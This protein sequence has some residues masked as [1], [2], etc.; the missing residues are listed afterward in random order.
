M[1]ILENNRKNH[2]KCKFSYHKMTILSNVH[3]INM[4]Q[5]SD[6]NRNAC[7]PNEGQSQPVMRVVLIFA[8]IFSQSPSPT[9]LLGLGALGD[10][11]RSLPDLRF[12]GIFG[13]M[14]PKPQNESVIQKKPFW[15]QLNLNSL[16]LLIAKT[17]KVPH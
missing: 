13:P 11:G 14:Q 15:F 9:F 2:L 4:A 1:C 10:G 17:T 12:S 8:C 16:E 7:V 6:R 3:F 5:D